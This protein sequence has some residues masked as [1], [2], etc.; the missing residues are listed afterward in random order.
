MSRS[1]AYYVIV[2]ISNPLIHLIFNLG[3]SLYDFKRKHIAF[4]YIYIYFVTP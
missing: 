3:V 1:S 4:I 2:T